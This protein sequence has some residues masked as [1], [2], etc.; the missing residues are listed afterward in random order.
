MAKTMFRPV[1]LPAGE[2]PGEVLQRRFDAGSVTVVLSANPHKMPNKAD[3]RVLFQEQLAA[4]EDF[5]ASMR[6]I[7]AK[8]GVDA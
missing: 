8:M 7:A 4:L 1:P 5:V 2:V 3:G 6:D